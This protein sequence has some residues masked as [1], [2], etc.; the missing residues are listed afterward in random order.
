[1]K[2]TAWGA[3]DDAELQSELLGIAIL[4]VKLD[5]SIATKILYLVVNKSLEQKSCD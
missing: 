1:M 5:W 2:H 4:H 3:L